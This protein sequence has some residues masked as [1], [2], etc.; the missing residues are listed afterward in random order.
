MAFTGVLQS[1]GVHFE[2]GCL[3]YVQSFPHLPM[4]LQLLEDLSVT[5][6]PSDAHEGADAYNDQQERMDV[7]QDRVFNIIQNC[8]ARKQRMQMDMALRGP[9][10]F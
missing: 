7:E 5:H 3:E 1:S 10:N 4:S 8:V 9:K 2:V 6:Q